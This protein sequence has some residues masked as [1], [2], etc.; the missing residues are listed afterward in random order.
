MRRTKFEQFA[1][2]VHKETTL[3]PRRYD[4]V[5][6]YQAI[7]KFWP[8]GIGLFIQVQSAIMDGLEWEKK[9]ARREAGE[10]MDVDFEEDETDA[11]VLLMRSQNLAA[12]QAVIK[13]Y[14]F[15]VVVYKSVWNSTPSKQLTTCL[16]WYVFN[17]FSY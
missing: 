8:R 6:K 11:E 13:R 2:V 14:P 10:E 5:K 16:T 4:K 15:S 9:E 17:I 3:L 12:Y 1:A 7:G